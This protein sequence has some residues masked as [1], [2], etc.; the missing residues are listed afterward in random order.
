MRISTDKESQKFDRQE[1][2]IKALGIETIYA[3]RLTGTKRDRP[4]LN[5]MQSDLQAGDTVYIVS[6]DRLSRYKKDLLV[7]CR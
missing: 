7:I 4:E 6:I 3:D 2:Q 1:E 5:K